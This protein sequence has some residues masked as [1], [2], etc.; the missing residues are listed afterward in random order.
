MW[1]NFRLLGFLVHWP[2]SPNETSAFLSSSSSSPREP[3]VCTRTTDGV[4][5]GGAARLHS[6]P[7]YSQP[8]L[9]RPCKACSLPPTACTRVWVRFVQSICSILLIGVFRIYISSNYWSSGM[10][11][12]IV[13]LIFYLFHLFNSFVPHCLSFWELIMY[14]S[15]PFSHLCFLLILFSCAD[16]H[17][18]LLHVHTYMHAYMYWCTWDLCV[19]CI[20]K[21]CALYST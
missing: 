1:T 15:I 21:F 4:Y 8:S 9:A 5:F 17:M 13:L 16:C 12:S 10:N 18:N 7:F 6:S 19:L 2:C 20:L 14:F 11:P 3:S